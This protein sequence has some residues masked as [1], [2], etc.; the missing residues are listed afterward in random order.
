MKRRYQQQFKALGSSVSL[1]LLADNQS[2]VDSAFRFLFKSVNAFEQRFS[3]FLPDSELTLINHRAGQRT[4]I[5]QA[6][7]KILKES[8]NL[9]IISNGLF[10]PLILPSLQ[11]A[12]YAGS[13]TNDFRLDDDALDYS[14]RSSINSVDKIRLG[15]DWIEIP[16]DA[17]IDLGGIGKGYLL[18]ELALGL[19][20]R[21][22]NDYWLS[23][24]GDIVLSGQDVDGFG[25]RVQ[26]APASDA[27]DIKRIIIAAPD[28]RLAM[29]TSGTIKRRG[30]NWHHIIDP[31]TGLP[32]E[33]DI[34]SATVVAERGVVADVTAKAVVIGGRL[35][36]DELFSKGLIKAYLLQLSGTKKIISKG[37][38]IK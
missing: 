13:I 33:T 4:K 9:S 16:S 7:M 29:A 24:G 30:S 18:D 35:V 1:T 20:E 10:S 21:D 5:S 36:A 15:R 27:H 11:R 22:I 2:V 26:I 19:N 8:V 28:E 25:W 12:G 14:S 37:D 34:M 23:L 6:M 32:A 3:R 31:A 17:A 38:Y